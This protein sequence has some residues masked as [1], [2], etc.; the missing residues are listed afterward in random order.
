MMRKAILIILFWFLTLPCEEALAQ[1]PAILSPGMRLSEV[2]KLPGVTWIVTKPKEFCSGKGCW[3]GHE[4]KLVVKYNGKRY[5]TNVTFRHYQAF[6]GENLSLEFNQRINSDFY[7]DS[8]Y[9]F[10]ELFEENGGVFH[11]ITSA[12][13]LP[14]AKIVNSSTTKKGSLKKK[15][16]RK[17]R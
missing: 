15:S 8:D 14:T 13:F 11:S 12:D 5:T 3:V 9:G 4:S 1:S 16:R 6:W 7:S 17:R 10:G 2:A